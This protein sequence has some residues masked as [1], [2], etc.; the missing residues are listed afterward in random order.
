[1]ALDGILIHQIVKTMEPFFPLKINKIAQPSQTDILFQCYGSSRQ[2]L[3]ISTHSVFN[4]IQFTKQ[5]STNFDDPSHFLTLLRKH[6]EGGVIHAI[7]Q[8]DLDRIIELDIENRDELGVLQTVRLMIELMGKYANI[9]LVDKQGK[10]LDALKRIPPFE[11]SKRIIFSGAAYILPEPSQKKDPRID[12]SADSQTSL[13]E[14]FQGFSPLLSREVIYRMHQ[15]ESFAAISQEMFASEQLYTYQKI[16]PGQFHIIALKHLMEEAEV[17]PIMEGLD[18]FYHEQEQADRIAQHTGGLLKIIQREIKRYRNKL[19]RL[20]QALED[21]TN[22]DQWQVYGD[23]LYAFASDYPSGHQEITLNDFADQSVVIPLNPKY[24]GKE[25][26]RRYYV[27]YHKG[28]TGQKHIREQIEITESELAYFEGLKSQCE[29]ADIADA[30]EIANELS[31]RRLF[32]VA[33]KDRPNPRKQKQPNYIKIT[34]NEATT[35]FIGKNNIQ[36]DFLT[37]KVAHKNDIWFHAADTF[38]AH[39]ICRTNEL[40][41]E[42]IRFCA[43]CAAYYSS[44]RHSSSVPVNYTRVKNIKKVPQ[45]PL[46]FV[47]ITQYRTIYIDPDFSGISPY[48]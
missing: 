29:Q 37:F 4:R 10:I 44:S 12:F 6:C 5:A 47:T 39:V 9:I 19:P 7:K 2:R 42:L 21:A 32:K 11:N 24:N 13:V 1:M 35:V 8:I 48:L 14:Q 15:G 30:K 27:K 3:F 40:N 33:H 34:F 43:N 22:I 25:N 26:A 20:H 17:F 38:G 45:K 31:S 23:L 28:K 16:T 41:E 46:G 18:H 36:N